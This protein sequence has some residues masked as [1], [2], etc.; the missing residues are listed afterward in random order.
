MLVICVLPVLF[1]IH[2]QLAWLSLVVMPFLA[3]GAYIFFSRVKS[4]F[5]ITDEAEAAMTATLQENLTG[6]PR[7]A[8][9]CAP[10]SRNAISLARKTRH[11]ATTTTA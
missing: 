7:G 6:N 9:I 11:S 2:V 5:Q 10:G 3:V 8:G 1:A 4:V